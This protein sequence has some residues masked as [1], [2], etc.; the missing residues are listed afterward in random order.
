M[1][2][3][4]QVV[5]YYQNVGSHSVPKF[6]SYIDLPAYDVEIVQNMGDAK[7]SFEFKLLNT[8]SSNYANFFEPTDSVY[9]YFWSNKNILSSALAQTDII[10]YGSI[11]T[12]DEGI[13][14]RGGNIVLVK[15]VNY[16]ETLFNA[17]VYLSMK[18]TTVPS[19]IASGLSFIKLIDPGFSITFTPPTVTTDGKP[20]K[21]ISCMWQYKSFNQLLELYSKTEYTGDPYNYYWYIDTNNVLHWMPKLDNIKGTIT[22]NIDFYDIKKSKDTKDVK[23]YVIWKAGYDI[24]N[25][26]VGGYYADY[27][28]VLK[29]GF[30]PYILTDIFNT[31]N[32]LFSNEKANNPGSFTGTDKYPVAYPY[33]TYWKSSG[34]DSVN[35]P[36]CTEGNNVTISNDGEWEKAFSRELSWIGTS[37]AKS[38][39]DLNRYGKEKISVKM[40]LDIRFLVGDKINV[41]SSTLGIN[42]SYRI[43]EIG[44]NITGTT[45]TF[46]EDIGS[47]NI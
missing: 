27:V 16:A 44:Y 29:N 9:I 18:D 34:T 30:K 6:G 42:K 25:T 19:V 35:L 24:R 7:D 22:E 31:G 46:E 26:V 43:K 33:T 13:N 23:N 38:F 4:F 40:K 5:R 11:A 28:S 10:M 2:Y 15:G 17:Y 36:Y 32:D 1:G 21:T 12:I 37:A 20:F 39:I 14:N 3:N 41:I 47:V 8:G 45:I